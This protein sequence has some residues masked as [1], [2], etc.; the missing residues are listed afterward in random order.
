MSKHETIY[1]TE[2]ELEAIQRIVGNTEAALKKVSD[3]IAAEDNKVTIFAEYDFFGVGKMTFSIRHKDYQPIKFNLLI[4]T[5]SL[6]L[7]FYSQV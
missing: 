2:E 1:P 6:S 5:G 7:G 3:Q 4:L